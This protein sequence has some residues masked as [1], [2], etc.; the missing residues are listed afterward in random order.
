[1]I[2]EVEDE[3]V[4][5]GL[6]YFVFVYVVCAGAHT[7]ACT[8]M[9]GVCTL[10]YSVRVS[11]I[12]VGQPQNSLNL[13]LP[14]WQQASRILPVPCLLSLRVQVCSGSKLKPYACIASPVIFAFSLNIEENSCFTFLSSQ[15]E[16]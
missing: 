13:E 7:L 6:F 4:R 9:S 12:R 8:P 11:H 2:W 3:R 14:G 10:F 16:N 5:Q 1:M 15:P